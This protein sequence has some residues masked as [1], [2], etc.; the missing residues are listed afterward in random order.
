WSPDGSSLA[1]SDRDSPTGLLALYL[2]SIETGER[3]KLTTPLA[4]S[5]GDVTPA[6]A[7]DGRTLAFSRRV[8]MW[9]SRGDL[10]VVPFSKTPVPIAEP[11][12]VTFD[13]HGATYPA[14]S[15]DGREIVFADSR[16]LWKIAAAG[17]KGKA[18]EP[19]RLSFAGNGQNS[20][21]YEYSDPDISRRGQ[22]LAY[23]H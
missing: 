7:P 8:D 23:T 22:R 18:A 19:Q 1:F 12:R 21:V 11:K 3:R 2:V 15:A 9:C 5:V 20:T 13:N 14:W 17:F 4:P 16:G 10:Y 6:F